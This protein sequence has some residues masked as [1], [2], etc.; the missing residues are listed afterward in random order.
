[1]D[2]LL[3]LLDTVTANV[4]K[5]T[6][7]CSN[8]AQDAE[9][10]WQEVAIVGIICLI[11]TICLCIILFAFYK[12]QKAKYKFLVLVDNQKHLYEIENANF[13]A[14]RKAAKVEKEEKQIVGK[15]NKK[16]DYQEAGEFFKQICDATKDKDGKFD[17]ATLNALLDFFR[18]EW[19][20]SKE[21]EG[22]KR[23]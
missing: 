8:C 23:K 18:E 22:K 14:S 11:V 5:V 3:I 10:N 20:N 9:T 21:S 2:N 17:I 15:E 19:G 4:M 7:S 16:T 6:H 1:M 12:W 13:E